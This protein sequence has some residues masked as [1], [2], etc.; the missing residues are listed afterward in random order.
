M[1]KYIKLQDAIEQKSKLYHSYEVEEWLKSL[2]TIDIDE[3]NDYCNNCPYI[4]Y[5]RKE[6]E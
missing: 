5:E 6:T 3:D 1:S 2:P 4:N